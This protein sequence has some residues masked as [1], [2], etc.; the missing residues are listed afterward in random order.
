MKVI[1]A[2]SRTIKDLS[3]VSK[4]INGSGFKITELVSGT[5]KGVDQLGEVWATAMGIPIKRFPANWNVHGNAAG[6]LRNEEMAKY[7]G[8]D[9][10]LVAIW[11]NHSRGTEDM[12]RRAGVHGL[13]VFVE[14]L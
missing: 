3:T 5:A 10:G 4:A 14:V 9:G 6:P 8:K 7:V 2:G 12:I 1:V 11:A 13:Q